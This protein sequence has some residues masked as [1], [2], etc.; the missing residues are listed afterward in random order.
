MTYSQEEITKL[1]AKQL[2]I[3]P[4]KVTPET[5]W[6]EISDSLDRL[7]IAYEVEQ[8][9]EVDIV[10]KT[11]KALETVGQTLAYLESLIKAKV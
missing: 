11:W 1:I 6:E 9:Y 8:I 7:E 4:E 2:G 5:K 10:D 3:A